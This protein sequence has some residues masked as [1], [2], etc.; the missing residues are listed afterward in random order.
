MIV[1]LSIVTKI[2]FVF[3]RIFVNDVNL[4]VKSF[5]NFN[6][7][8]RFSIFVSFFSSLNESKTFFLTFSIR[9]L[10]NNNVKISNLIV[11]ARRFSNSKIFIVEF[12]FSNSKKNNTIKSKWRFFC[13][14]STNWKIF[15]LFVSWYFK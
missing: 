4:R 1:F 11:F 2:T 9:I 5:I 15:C 14:Y 13:E 8:L 7:F 6:F 3:K 12:A 10:M